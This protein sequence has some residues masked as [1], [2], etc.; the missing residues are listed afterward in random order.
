MLSRQRNSVQLH[1]RSQPALASR[2]FGL[3]QPLALVGGQ[4]EAFWRS[5]WDECRVLGECGASV[6]EDGDR[7]PGARWFPQ[8]RVNY[9]R[10]PP[11]P[12]R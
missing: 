7:M 3:R 4:P 6:V 12:P 1:R 11:A 10:E 9:A 2:L 8:A 5:L